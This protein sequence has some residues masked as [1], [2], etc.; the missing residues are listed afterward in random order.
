MGWS[1]PFTEDELAFIEASYPQLGSA[2][3]AR[4]LGR[5]RRGVDNK[6]RQLGLAERR[7]RA[8]EAAEVPPLPRRDPTRSEQDTLADLY[9]LKGILRSAL[10]ADIDPRNI[11]KISAEYR[12]VLSEIDA[13]ENGGEEQDDA[14]GIDGLI[15]TIEL[16]AAAPAR[17]QQL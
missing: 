13:I 5:S 16:R 11:P 15:G 1:K 9:E 12:Q 17:R 10:V 14:S 2:E 8:R 6:V 4:R 7:A 3:I